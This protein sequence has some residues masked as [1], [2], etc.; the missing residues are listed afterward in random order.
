MQWV[1]TRRVVARSGGFGSRTCSGVHSA[2]ASYT[3][4]DVSALMMVPTTFT[5]GEIPIALVINFSTPQSYTSGLIWN[6][7]GPGLIP[8]VGSWGI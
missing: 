4:T 7:R 2:F 8:R 5:A 1:P 6:V 3:A